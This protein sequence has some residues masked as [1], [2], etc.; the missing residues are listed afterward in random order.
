MILKFPDPTLDKI[1]KPAHG[2]L[3]EEEIL[4]IISDMRKACWDANGFGISAIQ[5]GIPYRI[6]GIF[7]DKKKDLVW[8][9]DPEII[10]S[11][12]KSTFTEGCLSIPGYFWEIIRP[13]KIYVKYKE[14]NGR[15][16]IRSFVGVHSRIVQH[17]MDHLDGVLIPDFLSEEDYQ[18]FITHLNSKK[19]IYE[20][21]AP[22]IN[23]V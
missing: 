4:S 5:I 14:S 21:D 1:S 22:I 17:E 8:I 6:F 7:S 10:S 2:N 16:K 9:I 3:S 11:K 12:G 19:S 18:E 20:Y 15:S 23:M 13:D